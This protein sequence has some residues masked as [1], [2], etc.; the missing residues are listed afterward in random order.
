MG[1]KE[2]KKRF[3]YDEKRTLSKLVGCVG[4]QSLLRDKSDYPK[5]VDASNFSLADPF[6]SL[7]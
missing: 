3:D 4:T 1:E 6:C 5:K 2:V 7:K